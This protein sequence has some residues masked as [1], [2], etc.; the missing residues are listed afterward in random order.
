MCARAKC[1]RSMGFDFVW[2]NLLQFPSNSLYFMFTCL[3]RSEMKMPPHARF[4]ISTDRFPRQQH[5]KLQDQHDVRNSCLRSAPL[6]DASFKCCLKLSMARKGYGKCIHP[7]IVPTFKRWNPMTFD[8][9]LD[10]G[11]WPYLVDTVELFMGLR[12]SF[13]YQIL[14][15]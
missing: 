9:I 10:R 5:C 11:T 15:N 13:I 2:M 1:S 14:D 7:Y 4:S 6:G 12:L 3:L 8:Q